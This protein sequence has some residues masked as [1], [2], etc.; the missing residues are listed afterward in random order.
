M[1]PVSYVFFLLATISALLGMVLGIQMSASHDH[2]LM[3]VHA[4]MNLIGWVG[5]ALFGIF[6]QITPGAELGVL[7]K[8]HLGLTVLGVVVIIPGIYLAITGGGEGAAKLGSVLTLLSMLLFT[9]IVAT[10]GRAPV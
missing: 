9:Y 6:Y 5:M 2:S 4:H 10:R 8:I 3:P 1:K 7:P